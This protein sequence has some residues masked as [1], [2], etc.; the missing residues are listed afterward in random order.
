MKKKINENKNIYL[1]IFGLFFLVVILVIGRFVASSTPE[2][3]MTQPVISVTP[4]PTPVSDADKLDPDTLFIV[5][6]HVT[7]NTLQEQTD[8]SQSE[9]E[10]QYPQ[11]SGYFETAKESSLNLYLQ[12]RFE[13][14]KNSDSSTALYIACKPAYITLDITSIYCLGSS[15]NDRTSKPLTFSTPIVY[16][17]R[18][19]K[20]LSMQDIFK[21]ETYLTFLSEFSNK[22]LSNQVANRGSNALNFDK[23]LFT[24]NN[25][26]LFFDPGDVAPDAAGMFTVYVPYGVLEPYL[27]E[28]YKFSN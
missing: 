11:F 23:W 20:V 17:L 4:V 15:S 28:E 21:D 2:Q 18:T 19:Q 25:L 13:K 10:I 12:N 22:E 16:D 9:I 14:V 8:E 5:K 27:K 26:V 3:I 6:E 7:Y 1:F 24:Q